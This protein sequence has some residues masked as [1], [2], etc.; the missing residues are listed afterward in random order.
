MR[1]IPLQ[2]ERTVLPDIDPI[3]LKPPSKQLTLPQELLGPILQFLSSSYNNFSTG[4]SA[5]S[6]DLVNIALVCRAWKRE[7]Y[8]EL[9]SDIRVDWTRSRAPRL[10]NTFQENPHLHEL[11]K[12]VEVGWILKKE[13][14][15]NYRKTAAAELVRQQVEER[16][17]YPADVSD[18]EGIQDIDVARRMMVTAAEDLYLS[19]QEDGP[20]YDPNH[21]YK[22]F[23]MLWK[24]L[25]QN[26]RMTKLHMHEF[27]HSMVPA[28]SV[29]GQVATLFG[30]LE[31]LEIHH[32]GSSPLPAYI[33]P[34]LTNVKHLVICQVD[35][36]FYG[37]RPQQPSP[38]LPVTNKL[39]HFRAA[40]SPGLL[41]IG[42]RGLDLSNL[43]ALDI[44][45]VSNYNL[46]TE[47]LPTLHHLQALRINT[48][49]APALLLA[50]K[51]TRIQHLRV[52]EWPATQEQFSHVPSTV[53]A[54]ELTQDERIQENQY[55]EYLEDWICRLCP[56]IQAV[57]LRGP[58][59]GN[60]V[61]ETD[62]GLFKPPLVDGKCIECWDFQMVEDEEECEGGGSEDGQLPDLPLALKL[63]RSEGWWSWFAKWDFAG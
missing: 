13:A 50:V 32:V 54:L 31:R 7:A 3:H 40:Y 28:S 11:V 36:G 26:P 12:A 57:R 49:T 16:W 45:Y 14:L 20:W 17:P 19:Q 23:Q 39:T 44:P 21:M 24:W 41:N 30:R 56:S 2:H 6:G 37:F 27:A 34:L 48:W 35:D 33:M 58:F 46:L 63:A 15:E 61:E 10:V 22:G 60:E 52:D 42:L 62:L 38:P 55:L 53:V 18:E 5:R 25:Y 47:L 1:L 43:A 9:Y 4:W 51:Q 8:H 59:V 29:N